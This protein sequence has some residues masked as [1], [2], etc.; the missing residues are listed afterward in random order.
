MALAR[1]QHTRT[2]QTQTVAASRPAAN[3]NHLASHSI[4]VTLRQLPVASEHAK[5]AP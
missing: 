3:R 5:L 4:M 2:H 1:P